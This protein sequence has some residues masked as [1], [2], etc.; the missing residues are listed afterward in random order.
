MRL[1]SPRFNWNARLQMTADNNPPMSIGA[2]GL[3]VRHVQRALIDLG[4]PL[5]KSTAIHGSPDG[6]FGSETKN[7]VIDFQKRQKALHPDFAVDGVVGEQT[8]G[9][10]D[11]LLRTPVTLPPIPGPGGATD[12]NANLVQSLISVLNHPRLVEIDFSLMGVNISHGSYLLVRNA[13]RDGSIAAEN[14]ALPAGVEGFYLPQDALHRVTGA[15]LIPGNTFVMP[16]VVASTV[17]RKANVVHEATHAFCDIRAIGRPGTTRFTRDQSESVAHVAQATFHRILTGGPQTDSTTSDPARGLNPAFLKADE[18]AQHVLAK[19]HL[20]P[21]L[22]GE[23]HTLVRRNR[24]R[25]R[26]PNTTNFDGI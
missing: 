24:K 23:L 10:F 5:P 6:L 13:L 12:S 22:A 15:I 20:P 3:Y 19:R 2:A 4:H 17:A 21:A 7:A 11:R 14:H 8:M 25:L 9:A 1:T 26:L 18:L 16:F